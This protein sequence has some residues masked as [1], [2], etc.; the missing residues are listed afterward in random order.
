MINGTFHPWVWE[1]SQPSLSRCT[2]AAL[3]GPRAVVPFSSFI[4]SKNPCRL[5]LMGEA[6]TS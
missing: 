4:F 2:G 3:A 5:D 1:S 6:E